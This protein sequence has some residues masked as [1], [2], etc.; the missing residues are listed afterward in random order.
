MKK[1]RLLDMCNKLEPT[2]ND[3]ASSPDDQ[4]HNVPDKSTMSTPNTNR[5]TDA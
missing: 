3:Q 4:K 5:T 2:S 1:E